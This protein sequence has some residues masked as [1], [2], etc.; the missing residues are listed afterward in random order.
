MDEGKPWGGVWI[1]L[2]SKVT[3][4]DLEDNVSTIFPPIVDIDFEDP[5]TRLA[6]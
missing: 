6:C 3:S 4:F 5:I 2:F 1:V